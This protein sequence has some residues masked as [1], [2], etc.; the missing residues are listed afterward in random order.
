MTEATLLSIALIGLPLSIW[1]FYRI[2]RGGLR[3]DERL[4]KEHRDWID[5][6]KKQ[7]QHKGE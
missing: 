4:A 5:R 6:C 1:L 7:S 2:G 3:I